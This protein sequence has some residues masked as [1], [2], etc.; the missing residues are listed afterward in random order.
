MNVIPLMLMAPVLIAVAYCDLRYLRIPNLLGII[1]I[2]IFVL[3]APLLDFNE[4]VWRSTA[5]A[6]VLV[7][8]FIAFALR[9]L[10]GG[11]VKMLAALLLFIP[12][13]TLS[14]FALNFS[15]SMFL[16]ILFILTLRAVRWQPGPGWVSFSAT[17]K[18]PMGISIALSGLIHP[19]LIVLV[20]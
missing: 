18:F 15:A 1:S 4:V 16:G 10:G 12:S 8:G 13:Q 5:G 14:Y 2:V 9:L 3:T 11:D 7:V 19:F 6:I 17:G 20:T